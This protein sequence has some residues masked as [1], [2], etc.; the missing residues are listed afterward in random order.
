MNGERRKKL[1]RALELIGEAKSIVEEIKGEEEESFEAMP[2]SMQS[3]EK[4]EKATVGIDALGE[5]MDSLDNAIDQ[6]DTAK[7]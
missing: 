7:E 2:E 6:I 3:G 4:G 5:A 1:E